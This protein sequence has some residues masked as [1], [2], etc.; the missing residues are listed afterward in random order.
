VQRERELEQALR[1]VSCVIE[2]VE[3]ADGIQE[4]NIKDDDIEMEVVKRGD[5]KRR[6]PRRNNPQNGLSTNTEQK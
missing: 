1:A 2:K 4:N 5:E 6:E 3:N